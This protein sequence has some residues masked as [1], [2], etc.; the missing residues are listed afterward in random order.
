MNE[1][2]LLATGR[3]LAC[4]A[5]GTLGA[6]PTKLVAMGCPSSSVVAKVI[7]ILVVSNPQIR[8]SIVAAQ[9]TVGAKSRFASVKWSLARQILQVLAHLVE[10]LSRSR[11]LLLLL[12]RLSLLAGSLHQVRLRCVVVVGHV[13][14]ETFHN[15]RREKLDRF[16]VRRRVIGCSF[17]AGVCCC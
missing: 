7:L 16:L 11:L 10:D 4:C 6:R 5:E 13:A 2:L 1:L 3:M 12:Q 15:I 9:L 14:V 8:L 17:G